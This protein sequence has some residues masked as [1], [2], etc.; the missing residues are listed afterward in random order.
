MGDRVSE[1]RAF[2]RFYTGVVG[3]LGEVHLDT[4]YSLT[5]SR[6]I[7][8]LAQ[9]ESVPVPELRR[10]LDLDAG[11]LSRLLARFEADGLVAR[12]RD[13]QDARRQVVRL[14]GPGHEAHDLLE[15]R[16][17]DRVGALLADLSEEE[18]RE[19]LG[20]MARIQRLL[21]GGHRAAG[22]VLRAPR[23]GDL[24]WVV[25][26]HGVRYAE[27]YGWDERFEAMVARIAADYLTGFDP[28]R[29][30]GWIAEVDGQ[31]AGCVFCVHKDDMTAQLRMLLVEPAA[32][33]MGLGS[34]LVE[35]CLR[36]ARTA[37][38]RDMVLYTDN[39]LSTARHIYQRAGFTLVDEY[40]HADYG[41]GQV[42]QNWA[43]TL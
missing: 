13:E 36:F 30:A 27:E 28:R 41:S 26:R 2:N 37:G 16:T 4:P 19:L 5:E 20:A 15:E 6:L 38:Y 18:Q 29:D 34:R 23:P 35:E 32:R 1:V 40:E 8:E 14:L 12:Q 22:Y 24:G 31:R 43:M 10:G 33:G 39:S 42:A 7:F 3:A 25:H 21:G 17:V 11:Y 9:R